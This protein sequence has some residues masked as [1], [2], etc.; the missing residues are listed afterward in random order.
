MKTCI[1]IPMKDPRLSKQRLSMAL[2]SAQR[3]QLALTLFKQTLAFFNRHFPELPVLVVTGSTRISD[4][5][6]RHGAMALLESEP[7]GLNGAARAAARWCCDHGFDSQLLI[8]A[9]IAVLDEQEIRHLLSHQ[10]KSRSMVICPAEDGGTNALL[11]TPPNVLPFCYGIDSC[12]AHLQA[13]V[14]R[15]VHCTQ[16][17]L[18]NLAFDVDQPADLEQLVALP[19]PI[20]AQEVLNQWNRQSIH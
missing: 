15:G 14:K 17:K 7:A 8:P 9:D 12:H 10:R 5:A 1:V 4:L 3:Q 6:E 19:H 16:L 2:P 20:P 13:A 11:T 18:E